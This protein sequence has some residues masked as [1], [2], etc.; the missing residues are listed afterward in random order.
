[1]SGTGID[2][3]GHRKPAGLRRF[4]FIMSAALTV[5]AAA[6]GYGGL[7]TLADTTDHDVET[8]VIT[9]DSDTEFA[10][11]GCKLAKQSRGLT[12][13]STG[14]AK[15]YSSSRLIV[16]VKDGKKIDFSKYNASTVVE[17][18]FGVCLVQFSSGN[19]AKKAAKKLAKNS[20]VSY[21]EPD[22]C[23]VNIGDLEVTDITDEETFLQEEKKSSGMDDSGAQELEATE[24]SGEVCDP[25]EDMVGGTEVQSDEVTISADTMSWGASY[26]QADKFAAYVKANTNRSIKVAVVDSGVSS[27]SKLKGK[28]LSGRDFVDNDTNPSDQNGHGTHVAGIIADCTPGINVKIL[29]VRVIN[30]SGSGSPSVVGNGIRYAVN[31]GAKV[32]NLSLG[33][34]EHFKFI[35]ECITFAHNKGVTVVVASGNECENTKY[36][37]PAHMSTPIVVGAIDSNGRRAS[38]SNYGS[39]LDVTAPGVDIRSCWLGGRYATAS[40]TS[41]AVPHVSAAAAMY[42]LMNPSATPTRIEY[43]V[44]CYAKDLGTKGTDQ[45][46]GR[47]VPRMAGA[48][49]PSSVAFSSPNV[50]I[51]VD[52]TMQLKTVITPSYA[53][54]KKLTWSSSNNLVATVS[55]GKLVAENMGTATIT[56][57]TVNGKTATCKVTVTSSKSNPIKVGDLLNGPIASSVAQT[58]GSG[59]T[60]EDSEASPPKSSSSAP[61][62]EKK[63]AS[64]AANQTGS[65]AA[66]AEE[67]AVAAPEETAAALPVDEAA[68]NDSAETAP[69]A[70]PGSTLASNAREKEKIYI[71]PAEKAGNAP[72]Q[73]GS[74]VAGSLLALEAEIV[75]AQGKDIT[76]EWKSSNPAVASV[77]E[78]GLVTAVSAGEAKITA[79]LP[80]VSGSGEAAGTGSTAQGPEGTYTVKVVSPSVMTRDASYAAGDKEEQQIETVLRLPASLSDESS[81]ETP[82]INP[83]ADYVVAILSK[84]GDDCTLLGAVNLGGDDSGTV[85]LHDSGSGSSRADV[86]KVKGASEEIL[87]DPVSGKKADET[88]ILYVRSIN[89]DGGKADLS[90]TADIAA[91]RAAAK[92]DG[93]AADVHFDCVIAV[94]TADAFEE[95]EEAAEN[96]DTGAVRRIDENA[97]CSCSFSLSYDIPAEETADVP[98]DTG[99]D[100]QTGAGSGSGQDS[101]DKGSGS[102]TGKNSNEAG[103]T[104]DADAVENDPD[105]DTS[106]N[107]EESGDDNANENSGSEEAGTAKTA[108]EDN[109]SESSQAVSEEGETE[110]GDE[111]STPEVK[112]GES[113]ESGSSQEEDDS[114]QTEQSSAGKTDGADQV[115]TQSADE[116]P[117]EGE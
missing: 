44:R 6:A 67:A 15:P 86:K 96:N 65:A 39:S 64:A 8:V 43:L 69:A 106:A 70:S 61:A 94:Y 45:Y 111:S 71:Y 49:T 18:D 116:V 1:M 100:A 57:K 84:D 24:I 16:R 89:S 17:S 114:L 38:F 75:P 25:D 95:R 83:P 115:Q 102:D 5:M 85:H 4:V 90:L 60:V 7:R 36:I 66:S 48:I 91:L 9:T 47:G 33:A 92:A 88:G 53:G 3:A 23:S 41:M 2:T 103:N 63:G 28:L 20:S 22:D 105:Q 30:A 113:S 50:T 110:S 79:V 98:A 82:G 80:R 56:A 99:S 37:C 54:M 73:D 51:E 52:K 58:M 42:R 97:V 107:T 72:V 19:D 81:E 93:A 35:E 117:A 76:L 68:A 55:G 40:G 12:V 101:G 108:E 27:H 32:I 109:G 26:I 21:V 87:T 77:D 11:E 112:T 34:Y 14:E 59:I 31:N 13:Q 78:K 104:N 74:I 62:A 46:Y 29:P 10:V